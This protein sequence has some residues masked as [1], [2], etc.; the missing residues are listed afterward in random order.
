MRIE[1]TNKGFAALSLST[2]VPHQ[3]GK[4]LPVT[5]SFS[6]KRQDYAAYPASTLSHLLPSQQ[7]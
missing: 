1:L 4:T 3:I 7:L 5:T 6:R 2:W